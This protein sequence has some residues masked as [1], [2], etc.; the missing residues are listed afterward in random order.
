[1]AKYEERFP[2]D[3]RNGGDT[4]DDFAQKYMKTITEIYQFLNNLREHNS[5]GPMQVEPAGYQ[6]KAEDEKLYIRDAGNTEWLFLFDVKYR[7]GITDNPHAV[8]LTSD[9]VTAT[10]EALKLVK[11]NEQGKIVTDTLG[12]A[13]TASVLKNAIKITITDPS[14]DNAGIPTS[15]DGSGDITIA[16]PEKASGHFDGV[17]E[18]KFDGTFT[19]TASGYVPVTD[20]EGSASGNI[21]NTN[22]KLVKLDEDGLLPVDIRGNAGKLA[23]VRVAITNP[24]DGQVLAYRA[25]S[26]TWTNEARAVVG[27]GKALTIYDGDK[28]LAEYAGSKTVQVDIGVTAAT[29]SLS[30]TV[31]ELEEKMDTVAGAKVVVYVAIGAVVTCTDEATSTV[32]T[33]KTAENESKVEFDLSYGTY[34]FS[35]PINE[36]GAVDTQTINVT[37]LKIYYASL[38]NGED[39]SPSAYILRVITEPNSVVKVTTGSVVQTKVMGA[40]DSS[41]RFTIPDVTVG[42]TVAI[43]KNGVTRTE[44][45]TFEQGTHGKTVR[46]S[47]AKLTVTG[48]VGQIIVISKDTYSYT[49]VVES[50][51]KEYTIY[52]PEFGTWSLIATGADGE[53]TR[54]TCDVTDYK[55]FYVSCSTKLFAF[56]IDGTVSDPAK[57]ITYLE[58]NKDFTPAKM[59]YNTNQFDWG[60]WDSNEFFIP[61]PCMLRYDGTVDYYLNENDYSLRADTGEDSDVANP[62]Y[63]GNA[64]MEWGRYGKKIWYKVVPSGSDN[65]SA[66]IYIA[67]NQV[68]N[69][70]HAWSFIN[71]KGEMVDHFYTPIYN[72]SLVMG[73]LRS[74]SGQSVEVENSVEQEV[75]YAEA[76]NPD[77]KKMWYT[78]VYSDITLINFLLMLLGKNTDTQLTF[79]YGNSSGGFGR[80]NTGQLDTYG[81]FY[82]TRESD[83]KGVKAFGMENWWGNVRRRYAGHV[84]DF[85][86]NHM[87]KY[88]YGTQDGSTANSYN[89]T[90]AGYI[91]TNIAGVDGYIVKEKYDNKFGMIPSNVTNGSATTNYCDFSFSGR[92]HYAVRG[93]AW[94]D[95]SSCGAFCVDLCYSAANASSH[96]GAAI[97]CKPVR[98]GE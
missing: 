70:Y 62:D 27:E 49:I 81:M 87:V 2:L 45:V 9:D 21:V 90:G 64:M 66:T 95:D 92:N 59:N 57:M 41:V 15:F 44:T 42:S 40:T 18:G 23:G 30:A 86:G 19:G 67:D 68:D 77:D 11:T 36:E 75:Q 63:E 5:K 32:V 74:L 98:K 47:Y 4:V 76:N 35:T 31:K 37:E 48:R 34:T 20:V 69:D 56:K 52:I 82:G 85:G 10:T 7:M 73:R 97:S 39:P 3:Y 38:D 88:T 78:E 17:F 53:I 61:R 16:M 8:I 83:K 26:R 24:E 91:P 89:A 1:M 80:Q 50:S 13:A 43:T 46:Y 33:T 12:N 94:G 29:K 25:G 51:T 65:T 6:L 60:S 14:G 72:G 28:M 84:T 93:G 55:D 22:G 79:G 58:E 54:K 71:A 96:I